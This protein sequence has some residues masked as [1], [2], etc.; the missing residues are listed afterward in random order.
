M[1]FFF[2]ANSIV[3]EVVLLETAR[4]LPHACC[5]TGAHHDK[6]ARANVCSLLVRLHAKSSLSDCE[7]G[8]DS[9]DRCPHCLSDGCCT[10]TYVNGETA[11]WSLEYNVMGHDGSSK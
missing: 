2:W 1:L 6:T 8:V 4:D 9:K 11:C 5:Y 10:R 3:P 7:L